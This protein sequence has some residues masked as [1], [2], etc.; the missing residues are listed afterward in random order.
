M[1]PVPAMISPVIFELGP[2]TLRWYG[3]LVA[4]GALAAYFLASKRL[5][6]YDTISSDHLSN[7]IFIAILGA[8]AGARLFYVVR[9]W[10]TDF[11]HRSFSA[12]FKIQ[13]G[14]LVFQGG[15]IVAALAL[16]VYA[17]VK[18]LH[19]GQLGDLAAPALPL[20]H[21]IGR[22]GCLINGC[23]FGFLPYDGPC[24]VHYPFTPLGVFPAQLVEAAG[25]V[26]ICLALLFLERKEIATGRRF[27]IYLSAYTVLRFAVEPL[28]GD[29]PVDQVW[30]GMTPGQ[31]HALWQL[32]LI[33]AIF[34]F[35][36]FRAKRQKNAKA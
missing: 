32:P 2:L 1:L 25:N 4:L 19:L 27:L 11:A 10:H 3:V 33:M 12:V 16:I 29:Y 17:L 23:C 21:A 20:G 31:Y 15:F 34:A 5:R 26:L 22:I 7:I 36:T 8:L 14:G 6:R 18:H 24:A 28:R 35:F 13:E 30:A 9:F